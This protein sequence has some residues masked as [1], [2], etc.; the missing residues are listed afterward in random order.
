[1]ISRQNF[2][3]ALVALTVLF[4]SQAPAQEAHDATRI[5]EIT[6]E[7]VT[8]PIVDTAGPL[9]QVALLLDTS[10]SMDGLIN[11]ARAQ[12]WAIVNEL[13][14]KQKDGRRPRLEVALFEYGNNRLPATEN[15]VRQVVPL[16]SDLD[17]L[18]EALFALTTNGGS[19]YCGAVIDE[20]MTVLN[21]T[22]GHDHYKAIF[23]AGNEPFTQ[24]DTDYAEA[25]SRA[26]AEGTIVNTIHCGPEQAGISGK[27][28]HG[29][30]LGGG[31]FMTINQDRAIAHIHCPQD[32]V[33][34]KLNIE[35]NSTY[36]PFGAQGGEGAQRQLDQDENAAELAPQSAI[37]RVI[38]KS[39]TN[40]Y[41]NSVWDLVDATEENAEVLNE[42]EAESLP[43]N[44]RGKSPQELKKLV[45]DAKRKRKD[46]QQKIEK[47]AAERD[48][49]LAGQRAAEASEDSLGTVVQDAVREQASER[50]FE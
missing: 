29:A 50:G 22:S 2:T 8:D 46:V 27:W 17:R 18:S 20:A 15:Y 14:D 1:M 24:G 34:L 12:M 44:L 42:V 21:W 6:I 33:L 28:K 19:E 7:T 11:Q 45:A 30:A 3:C 39:K 36:I 37:R 38:S 49:F 26:R 40:A 25:C 47:V 35:L 31:K 41:R 13:A 9:I 10:N 16:T 4:G 23:I 5:V 43:P 32:D 48:A